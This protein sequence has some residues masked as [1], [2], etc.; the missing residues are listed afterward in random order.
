MKI[1]TRTIIEL[2]GFPKEHV[3]EKIKNIAEQLEK[4]D[5]NFKVINKEIAETKQ[6]E[7]MWSTFI[8][9]ELEF[10]DIK[11]LFSFNFTFLPSSIEVLEPEKIELDTNEFSDIINTLQAKLHEYTAVL[12]R[13]AIENKVL[14]KK[15]EK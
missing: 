2:A 7:K 10:K 4:K 3:E 5:Q 12:N 15:T 9:A 13:L 6:V 11:T 8:E 1:V 14:K